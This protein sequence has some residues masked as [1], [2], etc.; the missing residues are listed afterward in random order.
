M[1]TYKHFGREL[2]FT[3]LSASLVLSHGDLAFVH[4]G[5]NSVS[6]MADIFHTQVKSLSD[7]TVN[8][9]HHDVVFINFLFLDRLDVF[10]DE[11]ELLIDC[12][13][14]LR[15]ANGLI[16]AHS[17]EQLVVHQKLA[18]LEVQLIGIALA[19][20]LL[21]IPQQVEEGLQNARHL[22]NVEIFELQA[23]CF[24]VFGHERDVLF[25]LRGNS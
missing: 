24:P 9:A 19:D 21:F 5:C 8:T 13:L 17:S 16:L 12:V 20:L 1:L 10:L 14:L 23:L 18:L 7:P 15:L 11:A 22:Q 6:P 2:L 4:K 3:F 25:F